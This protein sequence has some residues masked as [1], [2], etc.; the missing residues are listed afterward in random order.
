M[1]ESI[2][3][4]SLLNFIIFFI[5]LVFAFLFGTYSYYKA[6]K[7]NNLMISVIEKYEGFNELAFK[8]ID[9]K[10]TTMAYE[11]YDF[12]CDKGTTARFHLVNYGNNE[13]IKNSQKKYEG[14]CVYVKTWD[15]NG[16]LN[17]KD[18]Y[19]SYQVTTVIRFN[20]PIVQDLIKLRVSSR[21]DRI[22]NFECAQN[23]NCSTSNCL[24]KAANGDCLD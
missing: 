17:S 5:L 24:T 11:R 12:D 2:G 3:S 19:D 21:T 16:D 8:E 20:F 4:V 22:Y 9:N 18:R 7:V 6:Y 10:L 15:S 1:R 14:F 13:E 23:S